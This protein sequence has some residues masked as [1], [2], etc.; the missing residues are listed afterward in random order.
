MAGEEKKAAQA[1]KPVVPSADGP[2]S[3]TRT[4]TVDGSARDRTSNAEAKARQD[5]FIK[6]YLE[7]RGQEERAMQ[8]VRGKWFTVNSVKNDFRC[9]QNITAVGSIPAKNGPKDRLWMC[10]IDEQLRYR[11]GQ[12]STAST[13]LRI[14]VEG[15]EVTPYVEG[16]VSWSIQTTG[17][18]N[19]AS[20]TVNN[21]EDAFIITP[22]N[23]CA[24]LDPKGWRIAQD[25]RKQVVSDTATVKGN[26]D[27]M[28]KY[29]IYKQ[30]WNTIFRDPANPEIDDTGM[31]LYPLTPNS[32]IFNKHDWCHRPGYE[33]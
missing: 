24:G 16:S 4:S 2:T 13:E 15:A 3:A 25:K 18:Q 19:S 30:K 5:E 22:D 8:S 29:L 26:S 28:A 9:A 33:Q 32:C 27:E 23:V 12:Y 17:G 10:K 11:E 7:L 31:W 21:S 6:K 14:F 20:F 1:P